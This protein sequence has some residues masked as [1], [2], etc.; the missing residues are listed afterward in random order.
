V[1]ASAIDSA[2]ITRICERKSSS[3]PPHARG[4]LATEYGV[5]LSK[6]T[7]V[8]SG[9]EHVASY[10]PPANVV[11]IE[12]GKKMADMLVAGELVAAIGVEVDHPDVKPLIPNALEAGLQSLRTR[13]LSHS[14]ELGHSFQWVA[15]P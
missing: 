10:V 7:W 9:D 2:S 12:A 8:L 11:P 13:G 14:L 5:D 4:I 15:A 6:V 3:G 1:D